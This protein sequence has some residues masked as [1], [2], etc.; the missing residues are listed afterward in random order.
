[1][2]RLFALML[3][4]LLLPSPALA[5]GDYTLVLKDHE[6]VPRVLKVHAG[7]SF[8]L[9]IRNEDPTPAAFEVGIPGR[10]RDI[11][12]GH[13][14]IDIKLK[15]APGNYVILDPFHSGAEGELIAQ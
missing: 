4:L 14:A 13:A 5:A 6:F 7:S 10:D 2:T 1:M 8:V 9:T 11:I 3:V 12:E 15:L